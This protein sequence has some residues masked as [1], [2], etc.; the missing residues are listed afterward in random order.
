MSI[1]NRFMIP[2]VW[3]TADPAKGTGGDP[4]K[5]PVDPKAAVL[6]GD[7]PSKKSGGDG[8]GAWDALVK[9]PENLAYVKTKGWQDPDGAVKSYRELESEASKSKIKLPD[10]DTKPE[11]LDAFYNQLGRPEKPEGYEFKLPE[12]LPEAFP[13]EENTATEF[14][15]ISHKLRLTAEQAQGLHDW[16]VSEKAKGF[17]E[18]V[19]SIARKVEGAHDII[20]K[21]FGDPKGADY[22]RKIELADR[23]VR[24]LGRT[25]SPK[26]P[27]ALRK[28][29]ADIG[30]I[31]PDGKVM[32]P[33]LIMALSKVG[34]TLYQEDK[35]YSGINASNNP[36]KEATENLTQ[37]G[38]ILKEDPETAR[39][40]IL[41][42]NKNP[43]DFGLS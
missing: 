14:K 1:K 27:G 20:V 26:D 42:A 33:L 19:G 16:Y 9:D 32:A 12:K 40:L 11:E 2:M 43:K 15:G 18:E 24:E 38:K 5:P 28:E 17:T 39:Q 29:L 35:V 10:K 25:V 4:A 36:W 30:A 6:P 34:D 31:T 13:Y 37:Q 21:E 7:D 8:N 41:A 23:S 3:D 22:K